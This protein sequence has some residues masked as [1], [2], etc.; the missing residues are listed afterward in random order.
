MGS[1]GSR[2]RFVHASSHGELRVKG[3]IR[4]CVLTWG[5]SGQGG[6]SF[7]RPPAHLVGSVSTFRSLS[8]SVDILPLALGSENGERETRVK[9][10]KH[11]RSRRARSG[12]P[13]MGSFGSRGLFVHASSSSLGWFGFDFSVF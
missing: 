11:R 7:M 12:R 1:F 6:D 3:A 9:D 10:A 13:H 4:S 5:A 2:G 8:A